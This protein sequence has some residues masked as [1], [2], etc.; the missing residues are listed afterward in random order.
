MV[1]DNEGYL[2]DFREWYRDFA[3]Q[4]ADPLGLVLVDFDWKVIDFV[5]GFY[6]AHQLMPLTRLIVKYIK[7][8]LDPAFDSVKLQARYTDKPLRVI[9]KLAGLPRPIQ[10]I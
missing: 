7:N 4:V 3:L 8:E 5:R 10:C 6:E 9:A 1:C 2:V